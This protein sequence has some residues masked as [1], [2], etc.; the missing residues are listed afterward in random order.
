ML[1]NSAGTLILLIVHK[2]LYS[3]ESNLTLNYQLS[4]NPENKT[5]RCF[6][7]FFFKIFILQLDLE[8]RK[9][10]ILLNFKNERI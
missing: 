6:H 9:F 10:N 7:R 2:L 5:I 4:L 3:V 1:C 8:T